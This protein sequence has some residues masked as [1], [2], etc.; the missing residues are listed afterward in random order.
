M[1]K[2]EIKRRQR[3]PRP[4]WYLK[5]LTF[6]L[7]KERAVEMRTVCYVT[8]STSKE[9]ENWKYSDNQIEKL[10]MKQ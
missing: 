1:E 3:K 7:Y 2:K 5:A 4:S 10:I 6:Y 9:N 8:G